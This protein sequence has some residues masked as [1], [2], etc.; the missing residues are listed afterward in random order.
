MQFTLLAACA[1]TERTRLYASRCA[2]T[3]LTTISGALQRNI[4][5]CMTDLIARKSSSICQRQP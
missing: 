3:S 4:S 2:A 1:I 5:I